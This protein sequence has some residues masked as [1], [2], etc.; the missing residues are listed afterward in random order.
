[1]HF[2]SNAKIVKGYLERRLETVNHGLL[3]ARQTQTRSVHANPV[4]NQGWRVTSG[5]MPAA[6]CIQPRHVPILL[7]MSLLMIA[8]SDARVPKKPHQPINEK[9]RIL[10]KT[11]KHHDIKPSDVVIFSKN[12]YASMG[13]R[14]ATRVVEEFQPKFNELDQNMHGH[15]GQTLET[16]FEMKLMDLQQSVRH[17]KAML[18]VITHMAPGSPPCILCEQK[19]DTTIAI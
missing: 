10:H 17:A 19:N 18:D 8:A 4:F 15:L 3:K 14:N 9:V 16:L 11:K 12:L 6:L 5:L 7:I 1:M 2:T 13:S